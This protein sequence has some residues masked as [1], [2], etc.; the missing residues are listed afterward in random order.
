MLKFIFSILTINMLIACVSGPPK[1]L[2]IASEYTIN[3]SNPS[4]VKVLSFSGKDHSGSKTRIAH[5]SLFLHVPT[6][7]KVSPFSDKLRKVYGKNLSDILLHHNAFKSIEYIGDD[8]D[9]PANNDYLALN[10]IETYRGENGWPTR[11]KIQF[12]YS[13]SDE[14][15]FNETYQGNATL[16]DPGCSHCASH[17][18]A[19][20]KIYKQ[21]FSAL[22]TKLSK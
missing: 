5:G 8:V 22:E 10:F 11:I 20:N 3:I 7:E 15:V 19:I 6:G 9:I 1:V 12:I 17:Y 18:I 4:D 14:I 21:F 2:P 16:L 13:Q